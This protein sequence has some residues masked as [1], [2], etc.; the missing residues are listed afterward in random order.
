MV[1]YFRLV[2]EELLIK[3]NQVK[4]FIKKHNPTIGV[5]TE[6]ILRTFLKDYLPKGISVEQGFI[7]SEKGE[8][9]KQCDIIIYDSSNYAPFYRVN[10]IVIVPNQSVISI[11][12]IKTTLTKQIFHKV[13]DYFG[14]FNDIVGD[15]NI[16]THLFIYNSKGIGAIAG[17]LKNYEHPGEYQLFDHDTFGYLPDTITGINASFHLAKDMVITERDQI[18]YS[19]YNYLNEDDLDISSLELF[20]MEIY[21]EV[22]TYL[23][24]NRPEEFKLR[25]RTEFGEKHN[26]KSIFAIP[27]FDM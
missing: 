12:E 11:I 9:S 16:N 2:S 8:L 27:L 14:S 26:L 20:Y 6:E 25:P 17:Y 22:E 5:L 23:N 18:G 15:N 10:E 24:F 21:S 19:S 1:R 13:I 3:L 4:E 7:L